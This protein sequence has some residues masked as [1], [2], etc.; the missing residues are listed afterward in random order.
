MYGYITTNSRYCGQAPALV[1]VVAGEDEL[2]PPAME[3][4]CFKLYP[5]PT[6][7]NFTIELKGDINYDNVNVEVYSMRGER[8]MTEKI[9]G[10]RKHEFWL[11]DLPH[12]LYYVK[13]VA[14]DHLETFKLV[15][16][17]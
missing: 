8:L 1:T 9:V 15:K 11:P 3:Q 2:V 10:E 7:G 13:V 6:S 16:T 12:G 5:N 17:R 14:D 4:S